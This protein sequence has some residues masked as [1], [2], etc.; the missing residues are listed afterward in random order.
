MSGL[1]YS[2]IERSDKLI[3]TLLVAALWPCWPGAASVA[4]EDQPARPHIVV[5]LSDDH[6]QEFAGCY[7]NSAI[8]TPNL[9]AMAR[10]GLKMTR[11]FAVTSS[12]APSRSVLYTG[13]YPSRNGAMANHTSCRAGLKSLPA[14]LKPLGYRVVLA[15]KT[16]I[17]PAE[18]FDFEFIKARLPS[19]PGK[20][21]RYRSEGLDVE[22]VDR[23]LAQH[24]Q[25]NPEQPLC[26]I[27]ADDNP[28]VL[29]EKNTTY[30]PA[31]LPLSPILVDTPK[32]R[33]ALAN[34]YQDITTM[35]ARIGRVRASLSKHGFA[36]DTLFIYTSDQ[37]SEWPKG[38]WTVYDTGLLVPFL[39]VWPKHIQPGSSSNALVSFVDFLPTVIEVAGEIAPTD[40][41]TFDGRSF[42]NILTGR[43]AA[44]SKFVFGTHTGDGK[45]NDF[46]QRSIRDD[47]Y[48][49]VLNLKPETKW[50]THFTE[51]SGIPDSHR[52]VYGT[53]LEK[54]KTDGSVARLIDVI[55]NHGAEEFYD[56][57]ADPYEL[58]NLINSP[59]HAPQI[60]AFHARLAKW[61]HDH[62]DEGLVTEAR[63][64]AR[65]KAYREA[66]K[67]QRD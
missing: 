54:A 38:K 22:A 49:Y 64:A 34:Y 61:M 45:M 50:K 18:V 6:G 43:A 10:E 39:A 36:D 66:I 7:G 40:P 15:N 33:T 41:Q 62:G 2:S 55:E 48:K 52:D 1:R 60:K 56:L 3:V 11:M 29:W 26:L 67:R 30:D 35:D 23:F 53:W 31:K 12:C 14:Y 37:G 59:K 47:R 9:D 65:D 44:H 25:E 58:H 8:K 16:H 5:Y 20:S 28:H 57:E 21:R 17:A 51:V 24:K 32:T 4:A 13:L 42:K 19:V 27:L 46:P 63:E